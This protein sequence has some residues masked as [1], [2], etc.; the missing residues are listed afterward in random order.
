MYFI[1]IL[2]HEDGERLPLLVDEDGQPLI[3]PNVFTLTQRGLAWRTLRKKLQAISL[4]HRW[5]TL[6]QIDLSERINSSGRLFSEEEINSSLL[7]FLRRSHRKNKVQKLAVSPQTF[8][9]L[10][11]HIKEY[12]EWRGNCILMALPSTDIKFLPLQKKLQILLNWFEVARIGK[13]AAVNEINQGLNQGQQELL[14]GLIDPGSLSNPW[15]SAPIRQRNHLIIQLLLNFGIRPSE[16][17]TL[18]VEDIQ[19]GAISS[20]QIKR[21]P[22]DPE[23][24]RLSSPE[25]KRS[26]RVM[27]IL[28][29]F[30]V[31]TIDDYIQEW[32]PQ[33]DARHAIGTPFLFLSDDGDPL[34]YPSIIKIFSSLKIKEPR[35][36]TNFSP[37]SLRH[38]FSSHLEIRMREAGIAEERRREILAYLRGDTSSASQAIYIRQA[39]KDEANSA[40]KLHQASLFYPSR[41]I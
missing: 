11:M 14:L 20:I 27:P 25:V 10:L 4:F 19:I 5:A 23:D 28:D 1:T 12:L 30:L 8:N 9:V 29:S 37:K 34:S 31:R 13:S 18:R 40:L 3:E 36:G 32:R 21:R 17:L 6:N 16:L 22:H 39:I 2:K 7:A 41:S 33:F 15:S 26:G 35:L 38:S 24:P